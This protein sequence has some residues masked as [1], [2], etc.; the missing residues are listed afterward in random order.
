MNIAALFSFDFLFSIPEQTDFLLGF[1]LLGYFLILLFLKSIVKSCFYH[2]K[3]LKKTLKKKV[4]KYPFFGISGIFFVL[5]RF[6]EGGF[7]SLRIF[8]VVLI[9]VSLFFLGKDIRKSIIEYKE[10]MRSVAREKP[11]N[12]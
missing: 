8:P 1:P 10:R 11:R 6:A 2:N 5:M 4:K 7:F 9:L 12:S 3:Y